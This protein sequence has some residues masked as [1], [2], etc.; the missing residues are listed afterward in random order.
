MWLVSVGMYCKRKM[1]KGF[2]RFGLK[3]NVKDDF[4]IDYNF[5]AEVAILGIYWIK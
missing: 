5:Y 4:Y 1:H 3:K 2:Q